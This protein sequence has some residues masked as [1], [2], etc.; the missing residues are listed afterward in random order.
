V[1]AMVK[2]GSA[3]MIHLPFSRFEPESRS[4]S[5]PG[6]LILANNDYLER[7]SSVLLVPTPSLHNP[8]VERSTLMQ[9]L[10]FSTSLK[11]SD[12]LIFPYWEICTHNNPHGIPLFTI[13]RSEF[14]DSRI[15]WSGI[16]LSNP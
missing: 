7:H 4:S 1:V 16:G 5:N 6:A 9:D 8:Q 10:I 2:L 14:A 13:G 11:N 3:S 12:A 15:Q